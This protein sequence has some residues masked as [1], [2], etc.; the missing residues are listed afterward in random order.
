LH[1]HCLR[2]VHFTA[3]PAAQLNEVMTIQGAKG[4]EA[5]TDC[6]VGLAEGTPLRGGSK[7]DE[8]A[9]QARL[10]FASMTRVK[11]DLDLFHACGRSGAVSFQ[12]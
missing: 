2:I 5:E 4:L 1:E 7:G 9:E 10:M 3:V 8:L 12:N 6:V 11:Q